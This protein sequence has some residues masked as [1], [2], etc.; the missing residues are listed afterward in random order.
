MDRS[1]SQD[2][3]FIVNWAINKKRKIAAIKHMHHGTT[4]KEKTISPETPKNQ[5]GTSQPQND[6]QG[7]P[8][9]LDAT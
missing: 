8:M 3:Q 7:D 2:P 1:D 9:E 5:N 6:N 4:S